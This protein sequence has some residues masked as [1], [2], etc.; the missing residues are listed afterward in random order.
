MSKLLVVVGA[1][2]FQGQSVITWF[3]QHERTWRIR[4]LTR[5]RS[6]SSAQ[7]LAECGAEMVHA[8]LND[9][10]SLKSTF[11]GANHI[12]AYTDFAGI[13]KSPA[14]LGKFQAGEL[15]P[16]VV[17]ESYKIEVQRGKNIAEA[18]ARISDLERLVWS[19]VAAVKKRS[20][21]KYSR[22]Y[23]FDRKAAVTDHMFS[24]EA[25]EGKVSVVVMGAFV[26]NVRE[27]LELFGIKLVSL[28]HLTVR[29][30]STRGSLAEPSHSS[31]TRPQSG[32]R[33][34]Q[35]I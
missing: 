3:Q 26:T 11:A 21:G 33:P 2:G 35:L 9:L 10:T 20:H 8:D 31:R 7:K 34:S 25:L 23:H 22:V 18:A 30:D 27:G 16:P 32:N 6:S 5:N 19:S 4:G 24:V 28:G 14:V 13:T 15:K 12:F 29:C 1:T 17:A